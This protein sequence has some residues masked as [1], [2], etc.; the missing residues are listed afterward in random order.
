MCIICLGGGEVYWSG[1][2]SSGSNYLVFRRGAALAVRKSCH[3]ARVTDH[4]TARRR[5]GAGVN[6]RPRRRRR[7]RRPPDIAPAPG[8]R[9]GGRRRQRCPAESA[10]D[11]HKAAGC[12]VSRGCRGG[13]LYGHCRRGGQR[14]SRDVCTELASRLPVPRVQCSPAGPVPGDCRPGILSAFL[15]PPLLLFFIFFLLLLSV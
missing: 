9:P 3:S 7:R 13:A 15:P 2:C 5:A 10:D 14:E 12:V 11:R 8:G 6:A 4:L 1:P